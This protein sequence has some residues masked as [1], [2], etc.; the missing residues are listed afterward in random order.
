MNTRKL[1]E[2]FKQIEEDEYG[3]DQ[4]A[5]NE[6]DEYGE[7]EFFQDVM[8]WEHEEDHQ[9]DS[10]PRSITLDGNNVIHN[11]QEPMG[12]LSSKGGQMILM[13]GAAEGR[14]DELLGAIVHDKGMNGFNVF[15]YMSGYVGNAST[16][17]GAVSALTIA[18]YA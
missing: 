8:N 11:G 17:E 7:E 2:S 14:G 4:G 18:A 9:A 13:H 3:R 16:I 10:D 15:H 6:P 12:T 1:L 5:L